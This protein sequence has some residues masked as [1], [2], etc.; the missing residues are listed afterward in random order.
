M[1]SMTLPP[2]MVGASILNSTSFAGQVPLVST[3]VTVVLSIGAFVTLNVAPPPTGVV[4]MLSVVFPGPNEP[5]TVSVQ[6]GVE[7][8]LAYTLPVPMN[9]E[10]S[11]LMAPS[12]SSR[13]TLLN[14]PVASFGWLTVNVA[15]LLPVSETVVAAHRSP[16]AEATLDRDSDAITATI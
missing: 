1:V 8:P 15:V 11:A 6:V 16:L 9:D 14:C 10:P 2:V 4:C 12:S 5:V 7:A 13:H 3:V